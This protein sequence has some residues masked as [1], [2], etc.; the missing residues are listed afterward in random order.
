M[1]PSPERPAAGSPSR[2]QHRRTGKAGSAVFAWEDAGVMRRRL[3]L[4]ACAALLAGC[5]F[6][7]RRA[8]EFKFQSIALA[9]FAPRSP[10]AAEI[11]RR[12]DASPT[13]RLMEASSQAQVVLQALADERQRV[14]VATTAAAQ[15]REVQ[16]RVRLVF[17]LRTS[18]GRE[19]MAPSELLL[20]RDISY[21]ESIALAKEQEEA[22]LFRAMES[23]IADQVMRRL[24]A[25]PPL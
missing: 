24:A 3:C 4:G 10:L 2:G 19:L 13:T 15:V 16:L 6:E 23:D 22:L 5:G 18:A 12:I 17:R 9:G 11:A 14:V 21:S 1:S 20:T 7:L 8:P 25:L